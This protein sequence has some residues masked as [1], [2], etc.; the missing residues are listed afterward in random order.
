MAKPKED[1]RTISRDELELLR[2]RVLNLREKGWK[3]NDIA[4]SF[5]LHRGSVSRWFT[6]FRRKGKDGLLKKK[7]SGAKPKISLQETNKLIS[8]LMHPATDFGFATPLWD[9][10]RIQQLIKNKFEKSIDQS[11]IWRLLRRWGFT[12]QKPEK[13]AIEQSEQ[14]VAEWLV[15]EWPK[16][17]A[18]AKRWH[19]IV[20]FQ[21]EAGISLIP[22][23]G[24]T[25]APRGQTPHV[26][27]TGKK[28]GIIVTS[29]VSQCGR[30][31]FRIEKENIVASVHIE[32]LQQLLDHHPRRKIIVVEDRAR[33][34]TAGLVRKF[35]EENKKR[36]TI[37]YLPSY[38]PDLNPDEKT[39]RHL[40]QHELKAHQATSIPELRDLVLAKMRSIQHRP[41]V[42]KSFFNGSYVT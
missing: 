26:I 15:E 1:G 19:A 37:Y 38:S 24:T 30:L 36:L 41:K 12:P 21:D 39:W 28:G 2:L 32:F 18:N 42:V 5:E 17:R 9:C 16:I 35:M 10:H 25:W 6:Y 33:P 20:Y 34:H 3:I 4:E 31:L 7:A 40:K 8:I 27:V 14:L 23:L 13:H 29:A 22:A 11:N